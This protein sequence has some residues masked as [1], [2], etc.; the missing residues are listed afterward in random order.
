[1]LVQ[2]VLQGQNTCN[3]N[4]EKIG[5]NKYLVMCVVRTRTYLREELLLSKCPF[6]M[7]SLSEVHVR[8]QSNIA[9]RHI[10]SFEVLPAG[11]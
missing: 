8:N 3:K 7:V 2:G 1:M 10:F 5:V 11:L 6:A 9:L 4:S